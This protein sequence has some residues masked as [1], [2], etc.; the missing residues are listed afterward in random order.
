MNELKFTTKPKM[1]ILKDDKFNIG[2]L[3]LSYQ[4][5]ENEKEIAFKLYPDTCG[6]L[7]ST[8]LQD[9][10]SG[11]FDVCVDKMYPE[12]HEYYMYLSLNNQR[13]IELFIEDNTDEID[14]VI[15]ISREDGMELLKLMHELAFDYIKELVYFEAS[16]ERPDEYEDEVEIID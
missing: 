2:Y 14:Y 7:I 1:E 12:D 16:T 4:L 5:N 9:T 13:K 10:Y 8:F 11:C 3:R 6:L 15:T